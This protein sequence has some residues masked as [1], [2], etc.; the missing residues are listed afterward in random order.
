MIPTGT[1]WLSKKGTAGLFAFTVV[2]ATTDVPM[3]EIPYDAGPRM[4]ERAQVALLVERAPLL[5]DEC[6]AA[7]AQLRASG[8]GWALPIAVA[9]EN[10]A[11][12]LQ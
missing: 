7:A 12:G 1:R 10:A 11:G 3:A 6:L 2:D 5:R 8:H 9:L 4:A